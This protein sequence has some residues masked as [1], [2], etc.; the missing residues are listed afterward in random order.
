VRFPTRPRAWPLLVLVS[1]VATA[2]AGVGAGQV[3]VAEAAA[4]TVVPTSAAPT[5]TRS[6][7]T[8]AVPPTITLA[9]TTV[10]S[11]TSNEPTTIAV[12][13][14]TAPTTTAAPTTAAPTTTVAPA[15]PVAADRVVANIAWGTPFAVAIDLTLYYPA[16]L[17]ER[18]GFH[19][20]G[21]DG[22]R[23]MD[24]LPE[25]TRP[26]T[27]AT[28]D[29]GTGSRTAADVVV[30]PAAELR[31]PV[32]GT[33]IRSGTYV[34]Y[35]KYTDDFVVIDPDDHPGWEVKMFHFQGLSVKPGDRVEAGVTVVGSNSAYLPFESQVNEFTAEPSWPHVHIEVIDPSIPNRPHPGGGC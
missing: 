26:I 15:T 7:S 25:A 13:T 3:T 11:T 23:Q 20:A 27:M 35:C 4:T 5:T 30:D 9:A 12:P 19:E 14:S 24:P 21:R 32:T 2:C 28:R 22:S 17:V 34:L 1:L 6:A 8:T 31:S 16:A 10:V 18:I 29:R 33:V